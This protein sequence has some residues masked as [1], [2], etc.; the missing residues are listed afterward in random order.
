MISYLPCPYNDELFYSVV[1]RYLERVGCT[2]YR[3][4]V[5][6]LAGK[7]GG[8]PQVD[9]Q[10]KLFTISARTWMTWKKTAEEIA[11][12]LTLYPYYS[13]FL[14]VRRAE[15]CLQQLC[16]S[17]QPGCHAKLG[18]GVGR[19]KITKHLCF[20]KKCRGDDMKLYGETYWHRS[21]QLPGV[22]VCPEHGELLSKT[23]A[24][25]HPKTHRGYITAM[26]GITYESLHSSEDRNAYNT[27]KAMQIARRSRE[28]LS[29]PIPEWN[30]ENIAQDYRKAAIERGF[31]DGAVQL[32]LPELE[33]AFIAFYGSRLLRM[34]QCDFRVG[35]NSSWFRNIFRSTRKTFHPLQHVLVQL[36][37]ESVT[38]RITDI[39][40]FGL[41]P[42]KCPNPHSDHDEDLPI[43]D[44]L[45]Y[46]GHKHRKYVASAKCKCG[47]HF[48]FQ[49]VDDQ[50]PRMPI[51]SKVMQYG[52][53]WEAEA[54]HLRKNGLSILA[55]AKK[56]GVYDSNIRSMLQTKRRVNLVTPRKIKHWRKEWLK[57]L[58][59]VPNRSR[60]LAAERNRGLY[61]R[62]LRNDRKWVLSE[63]RLWD[64][65][66]KPSRHI[67]WAGRDKRW[68]EML[69]RAAGAIR[70]A[71]PLRK[72]TRT[73][74][75]KEAGLGLK[76][77]A[78]YDKY[79]RCK[80]VLDKYSESTEAYRERR[81]ISR[82]NGNIELAA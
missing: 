27:I 80:S 29:R 46:V 37:L 61:I 9:L 35:R 58:E 33:K 39:I 42:W 34:V 67:E 3:A 43:K 30:G 25:M 8:L 54:R 11:N 20:C 73:A 28:M 55:I 65:N 16:I 76:I 47:Y 68:S 19:I 75:I 4:A 71:V 48:T 45:I 15:D 72:S 10:N 40:P 62:L 23:S 41:G 49:R 31:I 14:A 17:T 22:L 5:M 77:L 60:K 59:K 78:K 51:V 24:R 2:N 63:P 52:P 74:M 21:H 36:F 66:A 79:P 69:K 44:P 7:A 12:D 53:T 82:S 50:D 32:S 26:H 18:V 6:S 81:E 1:S 38:T 56:M 70:K 64:H 13:R 57:L